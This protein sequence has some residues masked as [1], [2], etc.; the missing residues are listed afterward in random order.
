MEH[1]ELYGRLRRSLLSRRFAF[2]GPWRINFPSNSGTIDGVSSR[3]EYDALPADQRLA[4][5][6]STTHRQGENPW[7]VT[8]ASLAT[9]LSVESSLGHAHA[10]AVLGSLLESAQ[11]Q[12]RFS[13]GFRGYPIRWFPMA[14]APQRWRFDANGPMYSAE[15]G[16]T[17]QRY[18]FANAPRDFRRHPRRRPDTLSALLGPL[19]P[20]NQDVLYEGDLDFHRRWEMSQDEVFGM[21]AGLYAIHQFAG[22]A[23]LQAGAGSLIER[24]ADYLS[25]NGYML[26]KPLGGI[27]GRGAGDSLVGSEYALGRAFNTVLGSPF[28][29]QVDWQ[30]AMARA[31]HWDQLA[32]PITGFTVL[33]GLASV[34]AQLLSFSPPGTLM[35]GIVAAVTGAQSA[36]SAVCPD[37]AA[38]SR[39]VFLLAKLSKALAVIV[40]N[41]VFDPFRESYRS[42]H[43]QSIY[44]YE[45]DRATRYRLYSQI[46][47]LLPATVAPV[48]FMAQTGLMLLNDSDPMARA[49]WARWLSLRMSPLGAAPRGLPSLHPLL[50]RGI[51][52][53]MLGAGHEAGLRD[54]LDMAKTNFETN[55]EADLE[56]VELTDGSTP[57]GLEESCISAADY[58]AGLAL[59]WLHAQRQTAAGASL[60]SGFPVPPSDFSVLPRPTAQD[61]AD[62]F[63]GDTSVSGT[64]ELAV[65]VAPAPDTAATPAVDKS[66]AVNES[67]TEVD[68]GITIHYGD[69]F[70]VSASGSIQPAALW[71]SN[72]PNGVVGPN[73]DAG[74]PLHA[75]I[76]PT[77]T[78][79]S[80]LARLNG[81]FEVGADS[82]E[83]RWIYD[84]LD[85]N[86]DAAQRLF[87]RIN[88]NIAGNGSG[89]FVARVRVWGTTRLRFDSLVALGY[90][91]IFPPT[92]RFALKC[93]E[94]CGPTRVTISVRMPDGTFR[95]IIGE[96]LGT[97][98]PVSDLLEGVI[99]AHLAVV[100]PAS[101]TTVFW[102]G[103]VKGGASVFGRNDTYQFRL[104][105]RSD[106]GY[107]GTAEC[108]ATVA[109]HGELIGCIQ[110]PAK[111]AP[112]RV[113]GVGGT[114]DDGRQ[115]R[116]TTAQAIAEIERGQQF[117]VERP[118]GDRVRVLVSHTQAGK[119]YLTTEADGDIP[120]NLLALPDCP[121]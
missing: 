110:R 57:T 52:C 3:A 21:L 98:L 75:G 117:F 116:L 118:I 24:Q 43:A 31:G 25:R 42:E 47:G 17:S 2:N 105:A 89:A 103:R 64:A 20:A 32:G 111:P 35:S 102:L 4:K 58:M 19:A 39:D 91:W 109:W 9:A 85:D 93:D 113:M 63:P 115:W 48:N 121:T 84:R 106:A 54:A 76:D 28:A 62:L 55:F 14:T 72:G 44:L 13:A 112:Q 68:T 65:H 92:L 60:V 37:V 6:W 77:N 96:G 41:D 1:I 86:G 67:D 74:W 101:V 34:V 88:D 8:G 82:G 38:A 104:E 15:F 29:S 66:I 71:G 97:P 11:A 83:R 81:W 27:V 18:D 30:G 79:W 59:A 5:R 7:A 23:T 100:N 108:S 46:C 56:L 49:E 119:K 99:E 70:R 26:V 80:L 90:A 53:L 12:F 33:G 36:L 51:A 120:N 10:R 95:P 45:Y 50:T 107:F 78:R 87:L 22:D 69:V 94:R 61:G 73:Q 40:H 114:M 16:I